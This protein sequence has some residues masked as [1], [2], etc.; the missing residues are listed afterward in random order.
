MRL[1]TG[2]PSGAPPTTGHRPLPRLALKGESGCSV[3]AESVHP[4][5]CEPRLCQ[6]NTRRLLA[7]HEREC[8]QREARE[9]GVQV[10]KVRAA[11]A[12]ASV[13]LPAWHANTA[14]ARRRDGRQGARQLVQA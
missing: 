7:P 9:G 4:S 2:D 11:Q 3:G 13:H 1:R 5:V 10:L 6:D 14:G 8:E 12:E